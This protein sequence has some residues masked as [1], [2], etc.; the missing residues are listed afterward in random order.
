MIVMP[1][2]EIVNLQLEDCGSSEEVMMDPVG[3]LILYFL[4][5]RTWKI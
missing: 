5:P 2:R 4:Y 1:G 3:R